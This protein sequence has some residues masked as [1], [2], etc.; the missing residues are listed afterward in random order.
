VGGE[1]EEETLSSVDA[2]ARNDASQFDA[3]FDYRDSFRHPN[4]RSTWRFPSSS[5]MPDHD[6]HILREYVQINCLLSS[7]ADLEKR[8]KRWKRLTDFL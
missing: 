8:F 4:W 1:G 7:A 5:A 3:L 2:I 6:P